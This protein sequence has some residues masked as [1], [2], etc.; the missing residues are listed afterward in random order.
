MKKIHS[1]FFVFLFFDFF[2]QGLDFSASGSILVGGTALEKTWD[3]SF[4]NA[5]TEFG[6]AYALGDFV[7]SSEKITVGGKIYYRVKNADD[8][9]DVDKDT[10]LSQKLDIKRAYIRFR[11]FGNKKLEFSGGKLYSYYLSGNYFP[12][13]EIYTG[14]SRWGKTG[15]GLKSNYSGFTFGAAIPLS[16][17]YVEFQN[18]CAIFFAGEYDFGTIFEKV[19]LS[20]GFSFGAERTKSEVQDAKTKIV[21]K[22]RE[23]EIFWTLSA[24]F[25]QKTQESDALFS[26]T[27]ATLSF[28]FNSEPFVAN[29]VYKNV[30]N[31]KDKNMARAHFFSLNFRSN[32]GK[33]QF[34]LEGEAGRTVHGNL[35]PLYAGTQIVLPIKG[36]FFLKPRFFYYAALDGSDS[37]N[38]R[39]TFE[40]Y[41]RLWFDFGTWKLSAGA[42]VSHKKTGEEK[43]NWQWS[44]PFYV[45][46][47]IGK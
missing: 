13:A 42:D 33:T 6:G 24:H 28:S 36:A 26:K 4:E 22:T 27:N 23:N 40:F 11:P 44:I 1:A 15:F 12:L 31:Y 45:E 43:W 14:S 41:P 47:K 21:T 30:A 8:S 38:S 32:L 17:S 10:A 46:Y 3:A 2:A 25:S 20:A 18:E 35:F 16:E 7:I 5:T 37:K 34:S 39:H 19:P 9:K 29:S